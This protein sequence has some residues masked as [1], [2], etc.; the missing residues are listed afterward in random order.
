MKINRPLVSQESE[1]SGAV[2]VRSK[3]EHCSGVVILQVYELE[4]LPVRNVNA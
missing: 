4:D 3:A 1:F 2:C